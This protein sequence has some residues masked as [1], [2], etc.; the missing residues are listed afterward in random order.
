MTV[1]GGGTATGT[2][3]FRNGT[4][5]IGTATLN[6]SG[7]AVLDYAGLPV[8]TSS[9]TAAYGGLTM[10]A[11][12]TSAALAQV[13]NLDAT[14]TVLTSSLNPS[15]G[16]QTVTFTATVSAALGSVPT[17][18]VKFYNGTTAIGTLSLSSGVAKLN[19]SELGADTQYHGDLRWFGDGCDKHIAGGFAGGELRPHDHGVNHIAESVHVGC[20]CD[21]DGDGDAGERGGGGGRGI[22]LQWQHAA[23]ERGLVGRRGDAQS[24][25]H[26]R[27]V[28]SHGEVRRLAVQERQHVKCGDA[29]G[30]LKN[31][32]WSLVGSC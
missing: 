31:S 8:G 20:E 22:V 4:A 30:E 27:D 14:L 17:G 6:G 19:D 18:W 29:D 28:Q 11:G 13:V 2:V 1:S 9:I 7:V 26:D 24:C 16:G 5:T 32:R 23:G 12:S 15:S 25:V 10:D 3:T 21:D